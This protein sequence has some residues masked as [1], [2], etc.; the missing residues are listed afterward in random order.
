[1]TLSIPNE[2]RQRSR[3][4]LRLREAAH[5]GPN[6]RPALPGRRP[7]QI[8]PVATRDHKSLQG[9]VFAPDAKVSVR[10]VWGTSNV[11]RTSIGYLE[12]QPECQPERQTYRPFHKR[13]PITTFRGGQY[14]PEHASGAPDTFCSNT[15]RCA[16][17]P[18]PL[19]AAAGI[20]EL[21]RVAHFPFKIGQV[22]PRQHGAR[23][24][25]RECCGAATAVARCGCHCAWCGG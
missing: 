15:A 12:C 16:P 14:G 11:H 20:G 8:R 7:L 24:L 2:K 25:G 18:L 1:M 21:R 22:L 13:S 6:Q 23:R 9:P 17:L 10:A 5:A 4:R 19:L 3:L